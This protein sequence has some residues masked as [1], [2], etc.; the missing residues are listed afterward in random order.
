M[1][2]SLKKTTTTS[3]WLMPATQTTFGKLIE[4]RLLIPGLRRSRNLRYHLTVLLVSYNPVKNNENRVTNVRRSRR[5]EDTASHRRK[6][7]LGRG[8]GERVSLY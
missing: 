5:L 6:L 2:Q 7:F 3:I 1:N 4:V 8:W